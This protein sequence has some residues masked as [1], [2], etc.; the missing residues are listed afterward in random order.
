MIFS[1]EQ[2]FETKKRKTII[3][4]LNELRKL[5]IVANQFQVYNPNIGMLTQITRVS[6]N[7]HTIYTS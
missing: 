6:C 1:S 5:E 7:L 4:K 2:K 3:I